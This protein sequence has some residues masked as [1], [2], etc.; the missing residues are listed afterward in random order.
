MPT[1][2]ANLPMHRN[3]FADFTGDLDNASEHHLK[4]KVKKRVLEDESESESD[5]EP[6]TPVP[7]TI[8]VKTLKRKKTTTRNVAD[9]FNNEKL[10]NVR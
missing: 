1:P 5:V 4:N 2:W 8:G 9:S 6:T 7:S 3:C 10:N